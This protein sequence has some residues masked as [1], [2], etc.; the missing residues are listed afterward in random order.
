MRFQQALAS[1]EK[2]LSRRTIDLMRLNQLSGAQF[3]S[4]G[5]T[6]IGLGYGLGVRTTLSQ[7]SLGAPV[8]FGPFGWGGASGSYGSIDPENDLCIFYMQH[9]FGTEDLRLCSRIRNIIYSAI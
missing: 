2:L 8:G 9:V 6:N 5:Y 3:D 4:Y 7:A 1:G